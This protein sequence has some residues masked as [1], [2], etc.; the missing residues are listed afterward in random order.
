MYRHG[1]YLS[2]VSTNLINNL[3]DC[4]LSE[5]AIRYAT[6]L[7]EHTAYLWRIAATY[8]GCTIDSYD[9]DVNEAFPQCTHHPDIATGNVSLHSNKMIISVALHFS[10]NYGPHSW[11]PSAQAW[12]FL[13]QWMY[14]H[15]NY[16]EAINEE[17]L[18]LME[19][20]DENDDTHACINRP[21]Y[22]KFNGTVNNEQEKFVPEYRMFVDDLLSGIP[23]L[24]KNTRQFFTSSIKLVYVILGYPG[25]ITKPDLPPTMSWDKMVG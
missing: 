8:P 20:P 17:V 14:L 15:T 12:C 3:V 18:D 4:E 2:E 1:S 21:Q 9:Y 16:Q 10:E 22:D 11:E 19:L 13:A 24:L 7:K 25:P 6:V 23:C 5:P